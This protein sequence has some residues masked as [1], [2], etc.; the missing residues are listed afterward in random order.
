MATTTPNYQYDPNDER[1]TSI[2]DEEALVQSDFKDMY[3]GMIGES[4]K[5]YQDQ[6]NA[7]KDWAEQQKQLQQEQT[8][9]TIEQIEQQ[10]DKA[11]KDYLKEQS[12]AYVDWRKQSNQ[13]GSEAEKMASAGLD[14]TGFSES[15]QVS[16]Y[17]TYQNRLMSARETYNQAVLNY[18]N[19][20][21]DARLQNNAVLAE[22]AYQ[23]LQ[24]QLE[25][26]L[27]GFQYKNNLI[28]E[29]ANKQLEIKQMYHQKWMDMLN[30]INTEK[31]MEQEDRHFYDNMAFQEAESQKDRDFESAQA[32]LDRDFTAQQN[33]LD[34]QH[35]EK[36]Q[37]LEQ[38]FKAAQAELDRKH[39]IALQNAK[40]KAEKEMLEIQH[41]ND[42]AKLA[43]QHK[44]NLAILDKELANEKALLKYESEQKS[45]AIGGGGSSGGG[46]GG[47]SSITYGTGISKQS[48]SGG[49]PTAKSDAAVQTDYYNGDLNPDAKKYGTFS[50]GY[51]PK[52]ITG[53]G[54]LTKSGDKITLQTQVMYGANKGQKQTLTQTVWKAE[55]GT[56]WYWEGRQNKYIQIPQTGGG[57]RTF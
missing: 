6:I 50:N 16:M 48:A 15:S 54:K 37:K 43:Q 21:K 18:D 22:I 42:L 30:Q 19:S 56:L 23:A 53:H 25:L 51:Q 57:G 40:T 33:I 52:G 32:Q 1:L 17:N 29:G 12:G 4:D 2:Q 34:R 3:T 11:Q 39:D 27:Q 36:I 10:K 13:Y 46:S 31:A 45:V 8:D 9:F 24:Q 5:Y 7:S 20:I 26:S 41:K 55:D 47:S 49:A 44:N 28:L 14:R 38:Q 35:E